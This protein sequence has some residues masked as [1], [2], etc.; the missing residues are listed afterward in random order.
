MTSDRG[1]KRMP[2]IVH[3][4]YGFDDLWRVDVRQ[5]AVL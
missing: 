2:L 5:R 4:T 3:D 1:I